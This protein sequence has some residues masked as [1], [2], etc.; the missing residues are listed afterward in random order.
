LRG[1]IGRMNTV[2]KFY[3][4]VWVLLALAAAVGTGIFVVRYGRRMPWPGLELWVS[5]AVL[6][7]AAGAVYPAVATPARL[8]D[9]FFDFSPTLNGM[10][11]MP[12]ATV[13]QGPDNAPP[14]E[15]SLDDDYK[16]I[17][18]LLDNVEGSPVILEAQTPEYR[19][20]SRV[21]IYTGLPTVIG[22]NW[23]QRQQRSGYESLVEQRVAE[24]QFMYNQA[25][26]FA[27]IQPQL[28]KYHVRYIYVGDLERAL[29][30]AAGLA[31]F[32]QAVADG[33]L[34][35]VYDDSG[36]KIY[37]YAGPDDGGL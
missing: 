1:D 3:L 10:A 33:D 22:W 16:A 36:V 37:Q 14:V 24:V 21:S 9:R 28:D 15:F 13:A 29:Y 11:Y 31:K 6:L 12:D 2:F 26:P 17:N 27:A 25:V 35:V 30:D 20:G 8:N 34:T 5:I 7:V 23:H 4:E 18:W 19:W 32:D